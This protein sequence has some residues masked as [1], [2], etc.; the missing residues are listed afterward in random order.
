MGFFAR[1]LAS[2]R[3]PDDPRWWADAG[4]G[5]VSLTGTYVSAET[6]LRIS[7]VWA[8]VRLISQS[9]ASIPLIV[10]RR[11]GDDARERATNNPLYEL[12]HSQPNNGM[13]AFEFKR[14]L[15]THALLKGTGYA[16]ILPGPRGA[17]DRLI[18][19]HPNV[20]TPEQIDDE[21]LRLVVRKPG[22]PE[23][24]L[25]PGEFFHVTGLSW[26][27]LTGV[28]VIEYA[29]ESMGLALA[30][31]SHGARMFSQGASLGGLL[32]HPGKLTAE[33][34][35]A[36]RNDWHAQH[37]G[38][39]NAHQVAVFGDGLAY[40][41]EGMS[42]EDA[43]FI[44]TRQFQIAD[45]AR[46]FGVDL[47]LLQE[48]TKSTS[49]GTGIEQMLQAFVTFTLLP[50][51]TAWEQA[52]KRDLI[53]APQTYYA[54]Y[55]LNSLVRG[56]M[57]SRFEAYQMSILAGWE[58]PAGV[59]R[60]E[61]ENPVPGLDWYARPLNMEYVGET[62]RSGNIGWQISQNGNGSPSNGSPAHYRRL[63]AETAGRAVRKERAALEKA[64]RR[65]GNDQAAWAAEVTEFYE[66]H[67]RF[68]AET[69]AIPEAA[70]ALY[71]ATNQLTLAERGPDALA[72]WLPGRA[73][74]LVALAEREGGV[75][76]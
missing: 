57:K 59:R 2:E 28:S 53:L 58:S 11:T 51:A 39:S 13:T 43:Q 31:E 16:R 52:I 12:L 29:R 18:P 73:D 41:Q 20:A 22:K 3:N 8:C 42:N 54:E 49:W 47:T 67:G 34:A 70:A 36:I 45:I 37:S 62:S 5:G 6:A 30:T 66:S 64:A 10:Y 74:A 50:W 55:L 7:A 23:E 26:D 32:V 33:Q 68:V 75:S 40:H 27:G 63:L 1:L 71:V 21:T 24:V 15:T 65:A 4:G 76:A 56:D 60:K 72:S 69:L 25:L 19:I 17:V 44:A 48:N 38:L 14:L 35:R 9:L 46:W 61:N